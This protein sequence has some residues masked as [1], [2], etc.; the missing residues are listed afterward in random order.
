MKSR[1]YELA[2]SAGATYEVLHLGC[3]FVVHNA[4]TSLESPIGEVLVDLFLLR[5]A[6]FWRVIGGP[7]QVCHHCWSRESP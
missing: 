7:M 6:R 3:K 1:G 4:H 5:V 2:L